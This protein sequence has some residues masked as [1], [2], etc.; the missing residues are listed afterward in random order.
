MVL[1]VWNKPVEKPNSNKTMHE[2]QIWFLVLQQNTRRHLMLPVAPLVAHLYR[3]MSLT[4]QLSS[5]GE[6]RFFLT[7][8][9]SLFCGTP[10]SLAQL[11]GPHH[12][13]T[14]LE[15]R[16]LGCLLGAWVEP[17][18]TQLNLSHLPVLPSVIWAFPSSLFGGLWLC[19]FVVFFF[20]PPLAYIR[21]FMVCLVNLKDEPPFCIYHPSPACWVP[22]GRARRA[23]SAQEWRGIP[24]D[25]SIGAGEEGLET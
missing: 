19:C 8:S 11:W 24:N 15:L 23:F 9:E 7:K 14:P 13:P 1:S 5:L 25:H 18:D 10:S 17:T 16:D 20:F 22:P 3:T 6:I 12:A 4:V 2:E 21:H